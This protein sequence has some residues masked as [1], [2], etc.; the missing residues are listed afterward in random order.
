MEL[1]RAE[2]RARRLLAARGQGWLSTRPGRWTTPP[3]T[4]PQRG[5]GRHRRAQYNYIMGAAE[6]SRARIAAEQRQLANDTASE[7]SSLRLRVEYEKA[8]ALLS[9][10]RTGW[11]AD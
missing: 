2:E 5:P 8:E 3:C 10:H 4:K 9:L 6:G 1:T 11:E 7:I